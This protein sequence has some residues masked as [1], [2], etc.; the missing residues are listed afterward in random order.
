V[1]QIGVGLHGKRK[2][3]GKESP[4]CIH[5]RKIGGF[6][7]L[8]RFAI[9]TDP[10]TT[11]ARGKEGRTMEEQHETGTVQ[12]SDSRRDAMIHDLILVVKSAMVKVNGREQLWCDILAST[13]KQIRRVVEQNTK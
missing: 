8:F 6:V 12:I 4:S 11:D 1:V 10:N 3:L 9:D 7:R 5:N 2:S 13:E